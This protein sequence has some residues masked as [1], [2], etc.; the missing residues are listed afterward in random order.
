[1]LFRPYTTFYVSGHG[2][3]EARQFWAGSGDADAVTVYELQEVCLSA[4]E[5]LNDRL[6]VRI[7]EYVPVQGSPAFMRCKSVGL[8]V[9]LARVL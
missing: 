3:R 9:D 6:L 4:L 5:S 2:T 8:A 1:M 7:L